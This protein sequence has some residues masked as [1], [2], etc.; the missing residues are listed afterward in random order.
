[1]GTILES[2]INVPFVLIGLLTIL[3]GV[4]V[5]LYQSPSSSK[6]SD[7]ESGKPVA[8]PQTVTSDSP[9]KLLFTALREK[10]RGAQAALFFSILIDSVSSSIVIPL[11]PFYA[12]KFGADAFLTTLVFSASAVTGFWVTPIWGGLSDRFGRRPLL[13]ISMVGSGLACLWFGLLHS[14]WALC[15][16]NALVGAT[17]GSGTVA[18][19][20]IADVTPQTERAKGM[21]VLAAAYGLGIVLGPTLGA[22]LV[23]ADALNPNFLRPSLVA[24]CLSATTVTFTFFVL[25][26]SLKFKKQSTDKNEGRNQT[27]FDLDE[28]KDIFSNPLTITLIASLFM[29]AFAIGSV[30]STLGLWTREELHWGPKNLSFLYVYWG[31]LTILVE[32]FLIAPLIKRFGEANVFIS[33][34]LI[35]SVASIFLPLSRQLWM[36]LSVVFGVCIGFSLCRVVTVSLLSQSVSARQQGKMLGF[37][38]SAMALATIIA[39]P[40]AGYT[41]LHIGTS[42]PFWIGPMLIMTVCLF[43]IPTITQSRIAVSCLKQ[44]QQN[45]KQLFSMLDY[46]QNGQ[47]EKH[48][49]EQ[50]VVTTAETWGWEQDSVEYNTTLSFWSGLGE[51]LQRLMDTDGDGKVSLDEWT[52][53][54]GQELDIDFADAFIKVLDGDCDGKICLEELKAFYRIYKVDEGLVEEKF[55][56]LDLDKNGYISPAEMS[57]TFEHF[58]YGDTVQQ[59]QG[60]W[61]IGL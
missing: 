28:F 9:L 55:E 22:F 14:F 19:A 56:T 10:K 30:Q 45:F 36:L 6:V 46:D 7:N 43:S 48:D 51:T 44:R 47:I 27:I 26:E 52:A 1:M 59:L 18:S 15:A 33:G 2:G 24:A 35:Y 42:W 49:F 16:C 17:A 38:Y 53:F 40:L 21:G 37:S 25:P 31:I 50:I 61:L 34:M 54:M 60:N 57:K 20:Y 11:I 13:M 29:V 4:V 41:F 3:I 23:G 5:F 32:V 39:P 12:E 8:P 58:L